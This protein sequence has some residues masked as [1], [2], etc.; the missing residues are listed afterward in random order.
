VLDHSQL[1]AGQRWPAGRVG[2]PTG[3]SALPATSRS[4]HAAVRGGKCECGLVIYDKKTRQYVTARGMAPRFYLTSCLFTD[5][6]HP[7]EVVLQM[8]TVLTMFAAM[9]ALPPTKIELVS[10]DPELSILKGTTLVPHTD[11][12]HALMFLQTMKIGIQR[13]GQ[14]FAYYTI[15]EN[16]IGADGKPRV[17]CSSQ[18]RDDDDGALDRVLQKLQHM[19]REDHWIR[20]VITV[21]PE[22]YH[23]EAEVNN[24]PPF[25]RAPTETARRLE[26]ALKERDFI[27]NFCM[28]EVRMASAGPPPKEKP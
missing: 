7:D 11:D 19:C 21:Y 16:T 14:S 15:N 1:Y 20:G 25:L 28:K 10:R 17:T 9:H 4:V 3:A 22:D 12:D 27:V 13:N 24:P 6:C 8:Y 26:K 2:P 18:R 23:S 5:N